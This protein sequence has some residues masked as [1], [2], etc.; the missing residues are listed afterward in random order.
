MVTL[1]TIKRQSPAPDDD[2]WPE[3]VGRI[4]ATLGFALIEPDLTHGEEASHVVVALRAQPTLQHFD[5]ETIDYWITE[6][7]RG[8]AAKMDRETRLPVV[9]DF[10]W[11]RITL[12][13]RLGVENGF[14]SFGGTMRA[15]A[16]AD[17]SVLVDFRSDA[18]ILRWAGHSQSSDPLAA[19]VGS[20]FA[21]IKVPIDFVP[22][23]EAMVAKA[24]PRTLYCSFIQHV[25]ERLARAHTL[26]E[27]NR[28]LADW[29][30][31]E[32]QRM[33]TGAS[34][35]WKAAIELRRQLGAIETIAPSPGSPASP[36]R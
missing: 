22:G 34:D 29:T 6:S 26:R 3:Q 30:A 4:L 36:A 7:A 25:Q 24:A 27:A 5:P 15:Q 18:P 11:G 1:M 8:R 10:S 14:L 31:R 35:Q 9:S 13:D 23:T 19:E 33:E 2:R 32:T 12:T 28:W 20:F 21:R 17:T 16:A